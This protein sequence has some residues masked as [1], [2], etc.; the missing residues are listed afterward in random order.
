MTSILLFYCLLGYPFDRFGSYAAAAELTL[1]TAFHFYV[2]SN[3]C[4]FFFIGE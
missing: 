2:T 1:S 3:Y 4:L